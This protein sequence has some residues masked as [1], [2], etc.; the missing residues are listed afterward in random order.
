VNAAREVLATS[1]AMVPSRGSTAV[2]D[3]MH[4][5]RPMNAPWACSNAVVVFGRVGRAEP[6]AVAVL[7]PFLSL[8][9]S[10]GYDPGIDAARALV[11]L[12]LEG[13]RTLL[14]A[15]RGPG[16]SRA[17]HGVIGLAHVLTSEAVDTLTAVLADTAAFSSRM[18]ATRRDQVR[19]MAALTLGRFGA[20][21]A[22]PAL[23]V[24]GDRANAANE[25]P[26][27]RR[28]ALVAFRAVRAGGALSRSDRP[29]EASALLRAE[30]VGPVTDP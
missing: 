21:L 24:L 29:R 28:V 5:A 2:P 7:T 30:P 15:A 4:W 18:E 14:S 3:E 8:N 6:D 11:G 9:A 1:C 16:V 12:G 19:G 25:T 26:L 22:T 27:V 13:T 10:A 23:P 17:Y 20:P